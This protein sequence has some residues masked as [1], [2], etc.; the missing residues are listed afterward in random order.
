MTE[1]PVKSLTNSRPCGCYFIIIKFY[2]IIDTVRR[3]KTEFVPTLLLWVSVSHRDFDL[4]RS[5]NKLIGIRV[6]IENLLNTINTK[7]WKITSKIINVSGGTFEENVMS[8]IFYM[9]SLFCLMSSPSFLF[10]FNPFLM[11][12]TSSLVVQFCDSIHRS[13]LVVSFFLLHWMITLFLL[14]PPT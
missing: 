2:L 12:N 11:A 8:H 4:M 10:S 5:T 7:H 14:E 9:V 13:T 6:I 1:P 3:N